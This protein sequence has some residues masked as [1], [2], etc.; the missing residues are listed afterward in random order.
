[1]NSR[2]CLRAALVA[3]LAFHA[4]SV[5]TQGPPRPAAL[6]DSGS[7]LVYTPVAPCRL[8]DTRTAGGSLA[9]GV[10]RSFRVTASDLSDQGGSATGCNVP[11]GRAT[12]AFV[13]FVAVN[14]VGA[15][16]LRAWAY[17]TPPLPAPNSSVLNYAAIPGAGL[18]VANAIAIPICD[19]SQPGQDCPLDFR[20]QADGNGTHLVADVVG[21]FERLPTE[22]LPPLALPT[23]TIILWDQSGT[24]PA[25]YTRAGSFDGRWL[26]GAAAPGGTGGAT[27]HGHNMAHTHGLAAHTHGGT[28][29]GGA[30]AGNNPMTSEPEVPRASHTHS[31]NTGGPSTDVSSGSSVADTDSAESIP[32]YAD[33]LLCRKNSPAAPRPE[34]LGD[35]SAQLLYTPVEPCR[36]IDTRGAGGSLAVGVPRDFSVTAADLGPQG[37]SRTG[38]NV[39]PGPATAALVNFVAVNPTGAGNLRAWAYRTPLPAPPNSSVLNYAFV[40]GAGLNVANGIVVPI[41]DRA[42]PGQACPLDFRAQADGSSTH[43][44]ADVVGY[45]ERFPAEQVPD[46]TVPLG[47][48]MIW[49]QSAVC[50][51]GYARDTTFDGRL[52]R[53]AASVGGT[54]GAATHTHG[55]AHTH[56]LGN[57]TH[58]GGTGGGFGGGGL[59]GGGGVEVAALGHTHPLTTGGPSTNTS[60][61]ASVSNSDSASNLPP[62]VDVLFCRKVADPRPA[63]PTAA[64]SPAVPAPAALGDSRAQLVYTPAPP[65]RIA[66]TR[67]AG[68]ALVPGTARQLK[69]TGND[70]SGQGGSATGCGVPFGRATAAVVNFVAVAP[71][72]AG[73]LRAWAFGTPLPAAP[74]SSVLNYARVAGSGLNIANA[75]AIPFC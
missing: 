4:A 47:A 10:P 21:F 12:V 31:I 9:P 72:G 7:K 66:D 70:L 50:P 42:Q 34:A 55:M 2:Q 59:V 25:G 23:G 40:A 33:V 51:A 29:G 28:T 16:N 67:L 74:N 20:V 35:S 14:A 6:G 38:C 52:P 24:C 26:R 46:L 30:G 71:T 69:A 65:C 45:F 75:I 57:H 68:G 53:A 43:L 3:G 8:V 39:P 15:G 63:R 32:P 36:L 62:F 18:N 17:H 11:P 37:G 73:N 27:S 13:N 19:P 54:G 44:V 60:G 49:D 41:C 48:M 5:E 22:E 64:A 61:P 58:S 56:T 1:M